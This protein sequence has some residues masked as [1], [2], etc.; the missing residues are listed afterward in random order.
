MTSVTY[1]IREPEMSASLAPELERFVQSEVES[2]HFASREAVIEAALWDMQQRRAETPAIKELR[3]LLA[4]ADED[5]ETGRNVVR[6]RSVAELR[7]HAK[8][9]KAYGR[10]DKSSDSGEPTCQVF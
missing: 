9:I 8:S 1:A 6:I 4:E 3:R 7:A 10:L 5:F 2:G